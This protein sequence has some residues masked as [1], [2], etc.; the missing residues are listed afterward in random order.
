MRQTET[1]GDATGILESGE[2]SFWRSAER[3]FCSNAGGAGG[4]MGAML[5]SIGQ[6]CLGH[7]D[8][9]RLR[10]ALQLGQ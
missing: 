2:N 1:Q 8:N 10:K 9:G 4:I 3:S 7:I 6:R 5:G